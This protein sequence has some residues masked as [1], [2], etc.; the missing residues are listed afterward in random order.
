[1]LSNKILKHSF[2]SEMETVLDEGSK[3]MH[4]TIAKKVESVLLD[5]T[6]IAKVA[7]ENVDACYSPIIHSGG[8]YDIKVSAFSDDEVLSADVIICSLGSRFKG[9]CAHMSRTFMV[10][11]KRSSMIVGCNVRNREAPIF[12]R[13]IY[14]A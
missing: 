1:M 9:Y 7:V 4:S 6:A 11:G 5:P 10:D 3:V 8:K 13:S 2:V 14:R 12:G